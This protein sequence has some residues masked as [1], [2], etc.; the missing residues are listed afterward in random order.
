MKI[1]LHSLLAVAVGFG[2]SRMVPRDSGSDG[3]PA[4][5][6][7]VSPNLP[8]SAGPQAIMA[9]N[10]T[11][12]VTDWKTAAKAWAESD[13]AGFHRWLLKRGIP[14]GWGVLEILFTEW[15]KQDPNAALESAVNLPADFDRGAA[16]S[17]ALYPVL[18]QPGGLEIML[19]WYSAADEQMESFGLLDR[20]AWL[21]AVPPERTA[22]LLAEKSAGGGLCLCG[23]LRDFS[24]WWAEKDR[25]AAMAWLSSLP[26]ASRGY[27]FSGILETWAKTDPAGALDYLATK[28]ETEERA[29]ASQ[30]LAE[31]AKTNPAAAMDWWETQMGTAAGNALESIFEPWSKADSGAAKNYAFSVED[32]TLRRACLASW[33][34]TA[35]PAEVLRTVRDLPE[36]RDKSALLRPLIASITNPETVSY[37]RE[38]VVSDSPS[39]TPTGA[40]LTSR[41]YANQEPAAAFAW[42]GGI[43][44]RFQAGSLCEVFDAWDDTVAASRAVEQLPDGSFKAKA[45]EALRVSLADP[46]RG[47]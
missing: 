39:M 34:E 16:L 42:V 12:D 43:P 1:L 31:M 35:Q 40:A 47:K 7:R 38:A 32:P 8:K 33:G 45:R 27:C 22:A 44:E 28:A 3:I 11:A 9:A 5:K 20:G 4:S 23:M 2:V 24:G 10:G 6:D 29:C 14:P 25:P 13:P 41:I 30:A 26:P 36:G 18:D 37:A 21:R 15:A 46:N 19:K 17:Y